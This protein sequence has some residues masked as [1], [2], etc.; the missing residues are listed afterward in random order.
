MTSG[1]ELAKTKIGR[2]S[3]REEKMT[4]SARV[5]SYIKSSGAWCWRLENKQNAPQPNTEI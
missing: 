4:F 5:F 2:T 3:D 1:W